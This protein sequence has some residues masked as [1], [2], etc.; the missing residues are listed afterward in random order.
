M[1]EGAVVIEGRGQN[2]STESRKEWEGVGGNGR[3]TSKSF[4]QLSHLCWCLPVT[5]P[6]GKLED[7]GPMDAVDR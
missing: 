1:P 7:K 4:F 5:E 6:T 3:N 2:H